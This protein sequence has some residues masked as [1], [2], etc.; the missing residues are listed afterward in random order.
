MRLKD[1]RKNEKFV[2]PS[3]SPLEMVGIYPTFSKRDRRDY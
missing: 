2:I 1:V 3:L